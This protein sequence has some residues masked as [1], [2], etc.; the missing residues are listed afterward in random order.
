MAESEL[1]KISIPTD[2][3]PASPGLGAGNSVQARRSGSAVNIIQGP[4]GGIEIT[5]RTSGAEL[6]T[7]VKRRHSAHGLNSMGS[8]LDPFLAPDKSTK[9]VPNAKDALAA[10]KLVEVPVANKPNGSKFCGGKPPEFEVV[11]EKEPHFEHH[12]TLDAVSDKFSTHIDTNDV[13][14]SR[15]LTAEKARQLLLPREQGGFGPNVLTPPPRVPLWMLFLLQFTNYLMVLLEVTALACFILY[16]IF[17]DTLNNLYLAVLLVFIIFVTCYETYSVEAKADDLMAKFRAMIPEK[18]D[19]IRDGEQ[20]PIPAQEIVPGDILRLKSGQKIPADCRVIYNQGMKVD[21]SMITGEADPIECSVNAQH[22]EYLEAKNIIFNGSLVVDGGCLAVAIRTGDGTLIGTMVEL[23]G[24]VGKSSSTLKADIEYFVK[25]LFFF[26]LFQ[27]VLIFI[28]GLSR[29]MN[30]VQ[31][32]INGFIIIMVGNVPE[33]LPA[34]VTASLYIVAMKMGAENVFVKKLDIIETLGSCTLI[35]TDKTGTLTLNLMSVANS[36]YYGKKQTNDEF[37]ALNNQEKASGIEKSQLSQL[38]E[39][40]T[41]NSRVVLERKDEDSP[42]RPNGDA[43]ELGLYR[44]FG[45]D[46]WLARVP[47]SGTITDRYGM[48]IEDFR[49]ANPKVWEIPFNSSNKW[50]MSI[51]ALTSQGGKEFLFIKGAPDVLLKKCSC[52]LAPDCTYQ[53]IGGPTGDFMTAFDEVY[54]EFGGKGERVIAFCMLPL[55]KSVA[56]S[57]ASDPEYKNKLKDMLVGT[58]PDLPHPNLIFVGLVTLRDPPR[59]EVPAAVKDCKTASVKVVMVT[60]DHPL[61]A[62]S[63]ARDIGLITYPTRDIIAKEK[64]KERKVNNL[65][66]LDPK[67]ILEEEI[68]AV[69]VK[70]SDIPA[71]TDKDWE[72]LCSKEEIVFARTSP[73]Q[74]LKIVQEFTKAGNVTAM[75]GD[76]VNDSP[77]L[78]QAAIGIAMGLNGSDVAKEAGDIVL[79]DDNFASIVVGIKEGRLLFANLKKSIAYTLSHLSP[80]VIPVLLWCFA[81]IPQPMGSLL[82]LCID[83]LTEILPATSLAYETP[84][85]DI[86]AVPPRN[87]KR[88][89]LTSLPLLLYAYGFAGFLLTGGCL[90]TFFR[91]FAHYGINGAH[92]YS[93]GSNYFPANDDTNHYRIPGTDTTYDS[94]EQKDI[95]WRI[96]AAWY[97]QIVAGQACHIWFVRTSTMSIF[98]NGFFR[99]SDWEWFLGLFDAGKKAEKVPTD[100]PEVG[101]EEPKSE[102]HKNKDIPISVFSNYKTNIGVLIAVCLGNFIVYCPGLRDIDQSRNPYSLDI[103]FATLITFFTFFVCTEA[104]K[105]WSRKP[106]NKFSWLNKNVLGW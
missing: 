68:K 45:G 51:H 53:D 50:Q 103:F 17:P 98:S 32:F 46:K 66:P 23:T 88:D 26:A 92:I 70:G 64:N 90:F 18:A 41:L 12:W 20:K 49:A 43:T 65:P 105:A 2:A 58:K 62:A 59:P 74:K 35:C 22:A 63:I 82:C 69:V 76:G 19:V 21:Q 81:G 52:Y 95:F 93:M 67:D 42:L 83:L 4:S 87:A 14:K 44:F 72:I 16:G 96:Q 29:G 36:W 99:E 37:R 39:I 28:V 5:R 11:E 75:T 33:G 8:V 40:C 10:P 55:E 89:K 85:A 73:E 101:Q 15:G 78:K 86:M 60:G 38:L 30:P 34:T 27:A 79:L 97:L 102:K 9:S 56:E 84:E 57:E 47:Y 106:E 94:A 1:I 13:N 77:A 71:M 100:D 54:E 24:D 104:R 25:V 61:T 91:G 7:A 6:L 80:E 48:E 31:V 3:P